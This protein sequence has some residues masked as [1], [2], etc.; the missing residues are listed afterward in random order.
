MRAPLSARLVAA[1]PDAAMGAFFLVLWIAP[2]A[3]GAGA[4]RTGL[5]IMLVEFVLLH[6]SAMIGGLLLRRAEETRTGWA[7]LLVFGTLYLGFIAAFAWSFG[8]WWPVFAFGAL[9]LG[10]ASL[11]FDSR[12]PTAD[13]AHRLQSG[14][15]LGCLAYVLGVLATLMLPLPRLGLDAAVVADAALVGSGH[16]VEH[17]HTVV[18]FGLLYFATHAWAK[19]RDIRLGTPPRPS[20]TGAARKA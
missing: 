1:L 13:R 8:E 17:P 11:A 5:L 19:A 6:A 20:S 9:L 16:W 7:M 3:L 12:L 15:A 2:R 10:K 14:W 4:L 18:A